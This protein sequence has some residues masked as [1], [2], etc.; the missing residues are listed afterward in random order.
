LSDGALETDVFLSCLFI[1]LLQVWFY[2]LRINI[3]LSL[4]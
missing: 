2:C 1:I 3:I 4:Y